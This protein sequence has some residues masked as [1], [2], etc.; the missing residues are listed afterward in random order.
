MGLKRVIGA[1]LT[2]ASLLYLA[3]AFTLGASRGMIGCVAVEVQLGKNN[4]TRVGVACN[5]TALK[6]LEQVASSE[7]NVSKPKLVPV[8]TPI[9][10]GTVLAWLGIVVG[11]W[12][13]LGEKPRVRR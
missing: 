3:Y 1:V 13:A 8:D 7:Y 4:V 6:K 12:L 10:L 9:A 11:P 5:T 2:L